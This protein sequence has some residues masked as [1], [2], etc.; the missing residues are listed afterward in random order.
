MATRRAGSER[1]QFDRTALVLQGGGAL[2]AYHIGALQAM[3]EAGYAP[4]FVAG[5]S[6]GAINA[7]LIAGNEPRDRL[8]KLREF[9]Q[10][11]SWPDASELFPIAPGLRQLYNLGSSLRAVVFGQP[12]FF[13]PRLLNPYFAAAG[14]PEATSFY[15]TGELRETLLRL[16][17]FDCINGGRTR[18]SLGAVKV[19]TG[20]LVFFDSG[21]P[22]SREKYGPIGPEHVMASGGLPPG[23]PGAR[24]NGELYWDGGCV[25]NTPLDG[26]LE[27]EPRVDTLIFMVDLFDPRGPEP[28]TMDEVLARQKDIQYASRSRHHSEQA[29]T[30]QQLRNALAQALAGLPHGARAEPAV[31]G[32]MAEASEVRTTIVRIVSRAATSD[33]SSRD[34]EFSRVSIGDRIAAG[35]EDMQRAIAENLSGRARAAQLR[36]AVYTYHSAEARPPGA[37]ALA[38]PVARASESVLSAPLLLRDS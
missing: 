19:T 1:A 38:N 22:N 7:A 21:D 4:D 15:D 27:A 9:W 8:A 29:A 35:Y 28:R 34:Y 37:A 16:V 5:I 24:I 2:G 13:R 17:D 26:V 20:E 36:S 3:E 32:L 18:L 25:S 23:L 12:N 10:L 31:R 6:I 30:M 14:T 11:I 33:L